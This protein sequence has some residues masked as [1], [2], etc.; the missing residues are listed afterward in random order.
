MLYEVI[1]LYDGRPEAGPQKMRFESVPAAV[2]AYCNDKPKTTEQI[3][4]HIAETVPGSHSARVID[5][6]L[7]ELEERKI[8]YASYNFV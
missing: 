6:A 5:D 1:T 4:A 8:L 2:I 7:G 3:H